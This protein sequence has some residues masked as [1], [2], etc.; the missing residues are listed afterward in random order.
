MNSGDTI[1]ESDVLRIVKEDI[2]RILGETK[3]K[4]SLKYIKVKIKV[5]PSLMSET[6]K[7][8]EEEGLISVEKDFVRLTKRGLDEAKDIAKRHLI[9]E[10]YFKKTRSEKKAHR[11]AHLLE[12]Y[13]S[14][15]VIKNIKRMF[16]LKKEG[17]PLT[18]F[19][20]NKGGLITD[21]MFS[22]YKLFERM[23]SMGILPG[24]VIEAT[25]IIPNGVI[26]RINNKKIILDKNI[27]KQI[28]VLEYE[29]S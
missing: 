6:I 16:T 24:K 21:I 29:K 8:L 10:N 2:L 20:L 4:V 13:V 22:D 7:I 25:Q 26:I 1:K 5:H 15:E 14:E 28:K 9:L 17:I 19:K 23:I 18:K 3:E 27:A 12:H 11:V